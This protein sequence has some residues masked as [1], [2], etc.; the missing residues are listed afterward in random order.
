MADGM[1]TMNDEGEFTLQEPYRTYLVEAKVAATTAWHQALVEYL[2]P[3]S[4]YT[5]QQLRGELLRRNRERPDGSMEV[6]EGFVLEALSG[7]L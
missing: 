1:W 2:V 7:D 3:R 5:A 4:P 6:F